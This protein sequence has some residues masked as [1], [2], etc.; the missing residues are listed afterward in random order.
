MP[1]KKSLENLKHSKPFT[2][3]NAKEMGRKGGLASGAAKRRRRGLKVTFENLL[4]LPWFKLKDAPINEVLSF[5]EMLNKAQNM[6]VEDKI[7]V[8]MIAA[9]IQ[10][11]VRAAEYIRDTIGETILPDKTAGQLT[12][13]EDDGFTEA[14]KASAVDVWGERHGHK[15]TTTNKAGSKV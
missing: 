14:L 2:K 11:N 6:T 9:A 4:Q 1:S 8:A 10:G 12:E 7:A 5:S 3:D 15:K 13:Y